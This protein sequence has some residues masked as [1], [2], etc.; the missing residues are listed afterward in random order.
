MPVLQEDL[1]AIIP[2]IGTPGDDNYIPPR[3][4]KELKEVET[5]NYTPDNT[6]LAVGFSDGS[7]EM[8]PL[9]AQAIELPDAVEIRS[10]VRDVEN[11]IKRDFY[12][13]TY[14]ESRLTDDLFKPDPELFMKPVE[15][16]NQGTREEKPSSKR[17][18]DTSNKEIF[19]SAV[20]NL[21]C[22]VVKNLNKDFNN[23]QF[24]AYGF[25]YDVDSGKA[26]QQC[27]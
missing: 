25:Y 12:Y 3:P 22:E 17:T 26:I 27:R 24:A 1:K 5:T 21:P 4:A 23:S 20:D 2:P 16:E 14:I 6:E 11:E 10:N 15:M 19:N 8:I 13:D 9:K 18:I 7:I